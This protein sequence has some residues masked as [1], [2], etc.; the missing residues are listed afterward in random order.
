MPEHETVSKHSF[1]GRFLLFAAAFV[2][3]VAGLRAAS[4]LIIPFLLSVFIAIISAQ[5]LFFL[6]RK[7]VPTILAILIVIIGVMTIGT[8]I[9]VI[10]GTSVDDFSQSV[11]MYQDRLRDKAVVFLE[12]LD[13]RGIDIPQDTLLESFNPGA[14]MKLAAGMLS[15]FKKVL[16]NAFLILLTVVFILL[17]A[18]D[19]PGKIKLALGDPERSFS[20]FDKT[21]HNVQRYIAIKTWIS[22]ATGIAIAVWLTMLGVD[23]P[24][25][26]GMLAFLLNYIP[27]IGSIIAAVPAV[28]LALI[29]LGTGSALLSGAGYV[30]VNVV[31]G[32]VIEPKVMGRGLGLSTL[33]VF[34]SLVFWGWVFG[35]VGM[36][37]SVPLTMAV[38]I[39][40][41]SNEDTKWIAV[42]LGSESRSELN[43]QGSSENE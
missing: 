28:L 3:V 33:V 10:I 12:W 6:K 7:R 4:S 19:F 21:I 30:V 31:V 1:A 35:P 34:L 8:V 37:L 36:L 38:K 22:L 5:P 43:T 29:Q 9:A 42:L 17:E 11:P 25:L 39:A 24:L 18:S 27:S 32:S 23:F 40:L 16:T 2:I 14:A 15:G 20:Y 13:N 41:D 26:W